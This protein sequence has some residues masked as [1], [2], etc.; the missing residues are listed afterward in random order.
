MNKRCALFAVVFLMAALL[1]GCGQRT[2]EDNA[3]QEPKTEIVVGAFPTPQA[4]I[5]DIAQESL[6]EQGYTLKVIEYDDDVP[7]NL[8]LQNGTL[9]ANYCQH[10][11]N[12]MK[13]NEAN[14]ADLL[15]LAAIH[16]APMGLYPG[17]TA[18]LGALS[19]GAR[20]AVPED[21]ANESRAL[22]L[23]QEQGLLQLDGDTRLEMSIDNVTE[24]PKNIE[25]VPVDKTKIA[26]SLQDFDMAV[27]T[28]SDA[29]Q[30][31][32]RLQEDA[33]AYEPLGA[34]PASDYAEI[35]AVRDGDADRPELLALAAALKSDAVRK[36][37][38]ET[39]DGAVAPLF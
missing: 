16:Y 5:L 33:I 23:L 17:K 34:E 7:L 11:P 31:G 27:L 12:L 32:L 9:D 36:F 37:I 3:Q 22:L 8:D 29:L 10:L 24:N 25:V 38:M 20:I 2:G 4:E 35:I 14:G 19:P 15:P 21:M 28:S 1:F 6:V 18:S 30:A 26:D 13:F 39:Y